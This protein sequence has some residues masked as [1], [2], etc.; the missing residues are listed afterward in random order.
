MHPVSLNKIWII[1]ITCFLFIGLWLEHVWLLFG[2]LLTG[3]LAWGLFALIYWRLKDKQTRLI[4]MSC[5]LLASL[6]EI[7]C[8]LVWGLYTYRFDN[9]PHYV[10]PGHVL[11]FM[12]G[13]YLAPRLPAWIVYVVPALA[14]PCIIL[15][16]TLGFDQFGVVLFA[17]FLGCLLSGH[18]QRMYATMFMLSLM[19]EIYGTWLGNWTWHANVPYWDISNTSPPLASGAFYCVLDFLVLRMTEWLTWQRKLSLSTI[20]RLST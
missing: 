13:I 2:Q 16:A 7:F 14:L 11:M 18:N 6:G 3:V 19:L 15:G 5:L 10:P 17:M 4:L 12:L 20:N 8:S 9:I 1:F